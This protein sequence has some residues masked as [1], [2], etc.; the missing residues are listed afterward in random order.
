MPRLWLQLAALWRQVPGLQRLIGQVM[1]GLQRLI[2]QVAPDLLLVQWARAAMQRQ[3]RC[4]QAHCW[5][6][7]LHLAIHL[8]LHWPLACGHRRVAHRLPVLPESLL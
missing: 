8:V 5:Q 7:L 3:A 6:A 4:W 2:G 1:A